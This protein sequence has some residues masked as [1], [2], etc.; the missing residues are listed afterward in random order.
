MGI[1]WLAVPVPIIPP[2]M[3]LMAINWAIFPE[4]NLAGIAVL[5]PDVMALGAAIMGI[6]AL[7][8]AMAMAPGLPP[9][10]APAIT[11][12]ERTVPPIF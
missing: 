11:L 3:G 12:G 6:R 2:P 10:L 8:P 9:A 4:A 5:I 7:P 1:V